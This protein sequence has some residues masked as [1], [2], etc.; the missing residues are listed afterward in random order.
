MPL[1]SIPEPWNS[2]FSEIDDSLEEEVSLI[3]KNCDRT[4]A[5]RNEKI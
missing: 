1:K 4:W 3:R 5:I 2:F